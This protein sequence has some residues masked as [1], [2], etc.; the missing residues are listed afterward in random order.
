MM[1]IDN[2]SY[3]EG[4]KTVIEQ[5]GYQNTTGP[6]DATITSL[7]DALTS[8]DGVERHAAREQL[9]E[10]GR[11]AVPSLVRALQS[12]S[13]Y[14]RWEAAKALGG[15]GDASAAPAL[16]GALEDEKSAVRWLAATALI[17]LGRDALAPLLRG[18][19]GNS[20]S[21]WFRD[22]AHHVLRDL[23]RDGVADEAVPVMEA[24]EDLEPCIEAPVA[25]YHVLEDLG[26][27]RE[28]GA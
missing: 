2:V 20:D 8:K 16:V 26:S 13:A 6:G 11:P 15:I 4:S 23:I 24:L 9:E 10:I 7:I 19:E 27:K 25:A 28:V 5:I 18:L 1:W 17:N 14:A 22:G 21:I 3:Y 12:P